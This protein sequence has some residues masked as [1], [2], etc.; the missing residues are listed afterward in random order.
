MERPKVA[1]SGRFSYLTYRLGSGLFV[2]V[3]RWIALRAGAVAGRLAARR[4]A[5][6]RAVVRVEPPARSS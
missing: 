1:R 2:L 5:E 3:P 6:R 4:S